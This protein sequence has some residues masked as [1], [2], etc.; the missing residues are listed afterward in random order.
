MEG[1]LSVRRAA[2]QYDIPPSTLH[3][4]VSGEVS[5]GA[6][7]GAPHCLDEDEEKELVS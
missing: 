6:V 1:I 2:A 7:S 3:D 4:C 5:A